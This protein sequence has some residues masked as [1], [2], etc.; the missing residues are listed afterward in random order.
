MDRPCHGSMRCESMIKQGQALR[1]HK[2]RV[3]GLRLAFSIESMGMHPGRIRILAATS[4]LDR[5]PLLAPFNE[6]SGHADHIGIA[7][8]P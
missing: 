1:R 6:A 4:L 5:E 8:R 3:V 7:H 2:L